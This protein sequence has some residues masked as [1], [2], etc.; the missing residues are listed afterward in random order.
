MRVRKLQTTDVVLKLL[1]RRQRGVPI[2]I[3]A[4]GLPL[5]LRRPVEATYFPL[6][7]QG[8]V[9]LRDARCELSSTVEKIMKKW[10]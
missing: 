9:S 7:W 1:P 5:V 3:R 6:A 2:G 8:L 10:G 4:T